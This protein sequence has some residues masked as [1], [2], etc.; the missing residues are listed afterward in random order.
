[1]ELKLEQ[2]SFEGKSEF[3]LPTGA[4]I[5]KKSFT[6]RVQEIENGFI[7][8]KNYDIQYQVGDNKEYAYF[9]KK[10]Y[11]KDNPMKLNIDNEEIPLEDKLG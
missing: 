10:W 11:S 4:T 6:I 1:M 5:I 8:C 2:A 3:K 7:I 9:D